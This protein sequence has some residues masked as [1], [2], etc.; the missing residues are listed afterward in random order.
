EHP[1]GRNKQRARGPPPVFAVPAAAGSL[2]GDANVYQDDCGS[3]S[4]PCSEDPPRVPACRVTT[5]GAIRVCDLFAPPA[6]T[7]SCDL[8]ARL[9]LFSFWFAPESGCERQQDVFSRAAPRSRGRGN[10]L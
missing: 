8:S 5:P 2:E 3:S 7:L 1:L 9:R 4:L 10:S 6:R